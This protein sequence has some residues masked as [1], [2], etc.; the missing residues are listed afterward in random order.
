MIIFYYKDAATVGESTYFK[1]EP[2]IFTLIERGGRLYRLD[3]DRKTRST[4]AS[5]MGWFAVPEQRIYPPEYGDENGEQGSEIPRTVSE[6]KLTYFKAGELERLQRDPLIE[7]DDL[8]ARMG[9][10]EAKRL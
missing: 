6:L 1:Y 2:D 5:A 3:D 10:L 8:K 7:I 9:K 4:D